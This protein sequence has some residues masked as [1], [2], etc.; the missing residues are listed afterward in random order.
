MEEEYK[1]KSAYSGMYK[2]GTNSGECNPVK[3]PAVTTFLPSVFSLVKPSVYNHAPFGSSEVYT[4]GDSSYQG[5]YKK[6]KNTGC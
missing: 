1:K 5:P 3:A 2:Y 6:L 4:T